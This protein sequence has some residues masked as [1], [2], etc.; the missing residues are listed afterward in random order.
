[1]LC[2][3]FFSTGFITCCYEGYSKPGGVEN[4]LMVYAEHAN[5]CGERMHSIKRKARSFISALKVTR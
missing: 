1:M 3:H 2:C 5:L 4:Q